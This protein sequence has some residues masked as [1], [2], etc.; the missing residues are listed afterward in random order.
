V[1]PARRAL[2]FIRP[3]RG[4]FLIGQIATLAAA[5]AGL[6]F[7]LITRDVVDGLIGRTGESA[8]STP[9]GTTLLILAGAFVLL[10]VF[11]LVKERSLRFLSL[12]VVYD[13]RDQVYGK[14]QR[15]KYQYF[16]KHQS[17]DIIS[18]MT[19][20]I[21]RFQDSVAGGLS[22]LL[23]QSVSLVAIV[24]LLFT[25]DA[26]LT[27]VVLAMVPVVF[28]VIRL[29]SKRVRSLSRRLQDLL[30]ELTS[31]AGETVRGIDVIKSYVLAKPAQEL[32]GA[33]NHRVLEV[34]RRQA[35]WSSSSAAI[36]TLLGGAAIVTLIG[37]GGLHVKQGILTPGELVAYIIYAQM[38]V[39]P[40]GMLS[41]IVVEVQRALAAIERVFGL[42]DAEEEGAALLDTRS[43][44][45]AADTRP[46]GAALT[47][48]NVTFA[49]DGGVPALQDVSLHVDPG[50]FVALVGPSGAGKSTLLKLLV[51]FYDPTA[52]RILVDGA[53]VAA[54][55]VETVRREMA[56]VMQETHLFDM[57]VEENLRCGNLAAKRDEVV[58]AAGAA[59]AARFIEQ[60]P[61]GYKNRI[62]E[63]GTQLSGGQR[64][65][66]SLARAF[67][68]GPR[69]LLL[70][71]ATSSLDTESERRIQ[72]ALG[73]LMSGRTTVAIAH[74]LSTVLHADRIYLMDEGRIIDVGPHQEL[75]ERSPLYARLCK[76]QMIQAP[77]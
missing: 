24:V 29:V 35:K 7:P 40:I 39:G 41:G 68:K 67:L 52:G 44:A 74:R 60:L 42:L 3:Y 6:A 65:R 36:S 73:R 48:E 70:D 2:S 14:I 4:L 50:E 57:S 15:L 8:G 32:F 77:D 16:D 22:F 10:A 58:D 25:I 54:L 64:Q 5:A 69:I 34:G 66:L 71:E 23:S 9:L 1:S 31:I 17:G 45:A 47:L 43:G 12:R 21:N 26:L 38:I 62:G 59:E 61:E 30:G 37:V 20:D 33:T 11:T 27:L 56:L 76:H 63:N 28:V 53:D 55:P 13:L 75:I 51:R 72:A 46:T 19:N 49:Y 18:T